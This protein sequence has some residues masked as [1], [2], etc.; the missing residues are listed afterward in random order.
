VEWVKEKFDINEASV[1]EEMLNQTSGQVYSFTLDEFTQEC[2]TLLFKMVDLVPVKSS[3]N[4]TDKMALRIGTVFDLQCTF[5]TYYE[6][7]HIHPN[8]TYP[9]FN[10]WTN[11]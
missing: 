2:T 7:N 10:F 1:Q 3:Q 6:N 9:T 5:R 4:S 11:E 8:D